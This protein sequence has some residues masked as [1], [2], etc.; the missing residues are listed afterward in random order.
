MMSTVYK[1]VFTAIV[2]AIN[3]G[4]SVEN[5]KNSIGILDIAGFGMSFVDLFNT[6]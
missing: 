4:T 2:G 1:G 5:F 3:K 6:D